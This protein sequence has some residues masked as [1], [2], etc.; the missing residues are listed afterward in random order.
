MQDAVLRPVSCPTARHTHVVGFGRRGAGHGQWCSARGPSAR[1]GRNERAPTRTTAPSTRRANVGVFLSVFGRRGRRTGVLSFTVG[2]IGLGHGLFAF[3][4]G[5]RGD[6]SRPESGHTREDRDG[7]GTRSVWCRRAVVAHPSSCRSQIP[8]PVGGEPSSRATVGLD[9]AARKG[10]PYETDDD[11]SEEHDDAHPP[12]HEEPARNPRDAPGGAISVVWPRFPQDPVTTEDRC[13][14][15][16]PPHTS[17]GQ[18]APPFRVVPA[19]SHSGHDPLPD[20]LHT[21]APCSAQRVVHSSVSERMR[22]D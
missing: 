15:S 18:A 14:A 3:L 1:A 2:F 20:R 10:R 22:R 13:P 8:R 11:Q 5:I 12:A 9:S 7:P 21:A 17:H 4:M 19:E 6:R 16:F